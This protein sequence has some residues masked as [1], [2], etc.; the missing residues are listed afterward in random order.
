MESYFTYER[1]ITVPILPGSLT[2]NGVTFLTWTEEGIQSKQLRDV[3][4]NA[5][6]ILKLFKSI[7]RGNGL[8]K[9]FNEVFI[10]YHEIQS[11][12][13]IVWA[14]NNSDE[15]DSY[16]VLIEIKGE[17][18]RI[19]YDIRAIDEKKLAELINA[20][21]YF[22]PNIKIDSVVKDILINKKIPILHTSKKNAKTWGS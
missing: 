22:N 10:P 13:R 19:V 3:K 4:F 7:R 16:A 18:D 12:Y 14:R 20:C 1:Y 11:I 8:D 21:L 5:L 17:K 15:F 9:Y 2:E 6:K